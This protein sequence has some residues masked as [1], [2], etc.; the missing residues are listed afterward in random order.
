M[1]MSNRS[2]LPCT[3]ADY[4]N[5]APMDVLPA[6]IFLLIFRCLPYSV[7]QS[8]SA[9][10][11]QWRNLVISDDLLCKQM[12]KIKSDCFL[13][14]G[15]D[16]DS[17]NTSPDT[18]SEIRLHPV[19]SKISYRIGDEIDRVQSP[20]GLLSESKYAADYASI[21]YTTEMVVTISSTI[22]A[23]PASRALNSI[24]FIVHNPDG[25]RVMDV[26][27]TMVNET[28]KLCDLVAIMSGGSFFQRVYPGQTA[29][30][31]MKAEI[32][33]K[34]RYFT[35]FT[36]VIRAGDCASVIVNPALSM[37]F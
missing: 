20:K 35:G 36:S 29:A 1:R 21:P 8:A 16:S 33:G 18:C 6:E 32:L 3:T 14:E 24:I 30:R 2:R 13:E 11:L 37:I 34:H 15:C 10:C 27:S 12:F 5:P 22:H 17:L 26:F 28:R 4:K 25:I 19:F 31:S 23:K 9:V 7:L